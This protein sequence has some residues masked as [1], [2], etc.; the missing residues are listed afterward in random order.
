MLVAYAISQSDLVIVPL[1]PSDLDAKG[2]AKALALIKQQE[3]AFKREIA[4][5]ILFTR[6]KAAIRTRTFA[7]I[8]DQLVKANIN[9]FQTQLMEREVYR[10][11]FSY[12]GTLST[13][14]EGDVYKL[15]DAIMNA[16]A[17]AGEV[18]SMVGKPAVKRHREV[19]VA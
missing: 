6:T 8:Q 19:E 5:A 13:L 16:R 15:N 17:F 10:A 7:H 1:Q 12:G 18:I 14:D 2:A 9:V 11:L 3:K 4:H